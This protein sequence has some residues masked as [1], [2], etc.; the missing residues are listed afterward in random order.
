MTQTAS[1]TATTERT[2]K[3]VVVVIQ[4]WGAF[5]EYGEREILERAG[6]EIT[7]N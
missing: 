6:C 1:M 2:G 7:A 4:G 5:G 3:P